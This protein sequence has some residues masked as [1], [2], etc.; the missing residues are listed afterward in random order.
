M[1]LE[2]SAARIYLDRLYRKADENRG[3]T[4]EKYGDYYQLQRTLVE[5]EIYSP[6]ILDKYTEEEIRQ[7]ARLIDPDKDLLFDYPGLHTLV[8]RYLA[9]DHDKNIYELSQERWLTIA[10]HLMQDEPKERRRLLVQEAY[11]ALSNLYMTAATPT[12]ANAGLSHGQLS[13]CF[14]DTVSDSLIDIY[15]SNTLA[16]RPTLL[17]VLKAMVYSALLEGLF[18]Y[19]GFAFFYHLARHQKMVGTSTMISYINRT[20]CSAGASSA[21]CSGPPWR[22]TRNITRRSSAA[23]CTINSGMPWSRKRPGAAIF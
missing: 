5:K 11:W 22:N 18:F 10:L 15:N 7:L 21:N 17:N 16:N 2:F 3:C 1:P 20:N 19:S 12:L 4:G 8:T 23:G 13:S 9:T 14:I 6:N